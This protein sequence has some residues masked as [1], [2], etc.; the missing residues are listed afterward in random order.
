MKTM[1]YTPISTDAIM[2]AG[3]NL[4]S[5]SK[6]TGQEP[7]NTVISG[8]DIT[9]KRNVKDMTDRELEDKLEQIR[10]GTWGV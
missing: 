1:Q 8:A 2:R 9:V 3:N 10:S 7:R 5:R 4:L 6:V